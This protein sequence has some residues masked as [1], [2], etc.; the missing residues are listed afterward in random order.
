MTIVGLGVVEVFKDVADVNLIH[1]PIGVRQVRRVDAVGLDVDVLEAR[2]R[3]RTSP[4]VRLSMSCI[5]MFVGDAPSY[6]QRNRGIRMQSDTRQ[7]WGYSCSWI[8]RSF[9]RTSHHS[10]WT[11]TA[12]VF[13]T[14]VLVEK[15]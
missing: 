11:F 1:G 5:P 6:P 10:I 15:S 7:T 3:P 13:V 8:G 12:A 14:A 4:N 2:K 9:R